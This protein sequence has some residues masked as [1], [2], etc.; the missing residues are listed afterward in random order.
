M[1]DQDWR[2]G[3]QGNQFLYTWLSLW[4]IA[5]KILITVIIISKRS[6]GSQKQDS[7]TDDAIQLVQQVWKGRWSAWIII[8]IRDAVTRAIW[9]CRK[10]RMASSTKCCLW[11]RDVMSDGELGDSPR[12]RQS[13][14]RREIERKVQGLDYTRTLKLIMLLLAMCTQSFGCVYLVW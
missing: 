3:S 6:D 10:F 11:L 5:L 1:W 7:D 9:N 12:L 8:K 13:H 4:L 2:A 14:L